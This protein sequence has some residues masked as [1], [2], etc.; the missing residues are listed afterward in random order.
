MSGLYCLYIVLTATPS[1]VLETLEEPTAASRVFKYLQQFIG[2]IL[3]LGI[4]EIEV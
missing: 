1:K 3:S 2:H 4:Q